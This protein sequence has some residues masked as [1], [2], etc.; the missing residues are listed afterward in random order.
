MIP[1]EQPDD[2]SVSAHCRDGPVRALLFSRG[3]SDGN[4]QHVPNYKNP[5][6]K[7]CKGLQMH[8]CHQTKSK[9]QSSMKKKKRDPTICVQISYLM[10]SINKVL[11]G[12]T[13]GCGWSELKPAMR[14]LYNWEDPISAVSTRQFFSCIEQQIIMGKK[15]EKSP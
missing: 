2:R 9:F 14:C 10:C 1:A 12:L 4:G 13:R 5:R 8:V 7:K 3:R 6:E 11:K 15:E